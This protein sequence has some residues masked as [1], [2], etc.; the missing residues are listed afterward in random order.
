MLSQGTLPIKVATSQHMRN[1]TVPT[2]CYSSDIIT[3]CH[4]C[5]RQ[6]LSPSE[7]DSLRCHVMSVRWLPLTNATGS[8][9]LAKCKSV[10][11]RC[12]LGSRSDT[13][14]PGRQIIPNEEGSMS[15]LESKSRDTRPLLRTPAKSRRQA[16]RELKC[17][18]QERVLSKRTQ[19]VNIV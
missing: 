11:T 6:S 19:P 14:T 16:P 12:R 18:R 9:L 2:V 15:R 17:A 3:I 5:W 10:V 4:F 8:V 13:T 7:C 1:P